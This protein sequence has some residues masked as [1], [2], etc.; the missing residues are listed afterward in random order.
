MEWY[1]GTSATGILE[2]TFLEPSSMIQV[3]TTKAQD[4][5]D[6]LQKVGE[7]ALAV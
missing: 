4:H 5:K 3:R 7:N 1:V 2:I 6:K